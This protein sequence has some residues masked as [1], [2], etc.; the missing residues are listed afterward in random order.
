[1][2]K[3]K[4]A[5]LRYRVFLTLRAA[6]F[7]REYLERV[8]QIYLNHKKVIHFRDGHPVYSLTTPALLSKPFANFA[9]RAIYKTIHNRITPNMMSFA[10]TDVC[11]ASCPHCS[12]FANMDTKG[13][14][15]LSLED[16]RRVVKQAQGLGVSVVQFLGGEP[17]LREDL[18]AII[19]SV[20]K[21]L[22]T[23]VLFTNGWHL[24]ERVRDLKMAGLDSVFI[25]LDSASP[26]THDAI[27]GKQGL[28]H[29][30][31]QGI[32]RS[33]SLGLS[34][35]ISCVM[36]PESFQ[37]GELERVIEFGRSTGVHEVLVLDAVP[38]GRCQPME[39]GGVEGDWTEDMIV[40][41]ERY[42]SDRKYPGILVYSY[43]TSWRS[44]GCAG[45]SS[46]FYVTPYGDVCPCDCNNEGFGNI[47]GEPLHIIWDRMTSSPGYGQSRWEGCR[48][49]NASSMR[50]FVEN[51]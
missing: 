49:K 18:P 16:S 38:V 50:D 34:T 42:N 20:D 24:A 35:G 3:A 47:L 28:F 6:T 27:R 33:R 17:L 36:T 11:N 10:V 12:F 25:S 39:D 45:G 46:Y 44:V 15:V 30:A 51:R 31:V 29:R 7:G 9:A 13:R 19:R 48:M 22:S 2:V 41:A 14:K 32:Q 43:T 21:D 1:M 8:Y 23:A 4:L 26:D 37:S 40:L 5:A